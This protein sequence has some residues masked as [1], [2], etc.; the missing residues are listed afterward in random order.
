[1]ARRVP[2]TISLDSDLLERIDAQ[3]K[4]GGRSAF[5]ARAVERALGS[6]PGEDQGHSRSPAP[7]RLP[8]VKEA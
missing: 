4:A 7:S 6:S 3:A 8:S 1:M 5:I 2:V